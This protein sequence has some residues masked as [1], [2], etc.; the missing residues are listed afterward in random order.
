MSELT[1]LDATGQAELVRRGDVKPAELVEAA[2]ARIE[3]VDPELNAVVTPMFEDALERARGELP[4][5][6]FAGVPYLL[7]DFGE[8][9][10]AGVRFTEGSGFL[11]D[12]VP[13][14]DGEMVRRLR[15]AGFVICGKTNTPEFGILPT[16][17]GA[18]L[19]AAR[20]PWD[21][22]RSPG[23]SSGGSAAAVAARMVPA[24]YGNDGGGS[25]RIPG[26]CCGLFGLKPTRARNTMAPK[27]G[28]FAGGIAEAHA[29][30]VSVRDSARIL[31]ATCGPAPGDPSMA[32]P[33]SRPFAEEVGADP[34]RLRI[35]STAEA[36]TGVPVDD[37]CR[38]AVA[39][40]AELLEE[41]GHQVSELRIPVDGERL[42]DAFI[43]VWAS[44][45]AW[46]CRHWSRRTDRE[47]A[48][49]DV[50]P[51]TWALKEMGEGRTSVDYLEAWETL[52]LLSRD[53]AGLYD[54]V[55]VVL[56]PTIAEAR[57]R[58]GSSTPPPRT[59]CGG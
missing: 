23:G 26:S 50:E 53:F 56:T 38:R 27:F 24:A 55:D 32:P 8:V 58:S 51:L 47:M 33:P 19:G 3:A 1:A 52:H 9:E 2:I 13:P 40:T 34:G 15:R 12:F 48:P 39:E 54:D 28:E 42:T 43:T 6:P 17:E 44:G 37:D 11:A 7:K 16:T 10:V 57:P 36:P 31:D 22:S 5:G 14:T 45:T 59:P 21:T 49:D 20:N 29:L 18:F 46:V 41:L 4:E 35:G 25:I 30:T